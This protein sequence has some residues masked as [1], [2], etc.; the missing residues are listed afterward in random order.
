MTVTGLSDSETHFGV[1]AVATAQ[2]AGV[3]LVHVLVADDAGALV[4]VLHRGEQRGR[5]NCHGRHQT[6]L[7]KGR[8][9]GRGQMKRG[10]T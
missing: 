5:G 7:L 1:E 4:I 8:E 10:S 9:R 3:A 6:L 2:S